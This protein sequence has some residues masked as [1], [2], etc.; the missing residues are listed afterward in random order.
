MVKPWFPVDFR[1]KTKETTAFPQQRS[2]FVPG[3]ELHGQGGRA[4]CG[5]AETLPGWQVS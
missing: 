5:A 1:D 2:R 4:A 3:L